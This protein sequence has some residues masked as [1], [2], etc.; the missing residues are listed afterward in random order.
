[1]TKNINFHELAALSATE[2]GRLLMRT[3][4]DLSH[5][6]PRVQTIMDE[7]KTGG[8]NALRRL[9]LEL[10]KADIS[11]NGL[12]ATEAEFDAAEKT[13]APELREAMQFAAGSI[14]R[15]HQDQMPEEMWL[16]EIRPGAFC[17]DR[18][19]PIPSVACYVPRGKGAFPSVAMMTTLP[20]K[21]AGVRK[22]AIFTPP[23]EEGKVDAATLFAAR[24][25]GVTEVYKAG[26]AQAVAAA[27]FGTETIPKFAKIIGPGSP[28]VAAAKRLVTHLI[29]TG[30]PAGPSELIVLADE[31]ADGRLAGLDLLIEAEHGPDSSAYLVTWSRSVAEAA[32][33]AIPEYWRSMG[34]QRVA[35]SSAVLSGPIGGIVL[36]RDRREAIA[37]INDYAPEHL[38]ILSK[39]P[40]QYL[41]EIEHAGE[42]LLGE[43]TPVTLGNFVLGPNHVLPTNGWA[44]TASPV[45]VYDFLKRTSIAYVTSSGYPEVARHARTLARYEGF[46]AHANAVSPIRKR[47]LG[48]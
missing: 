2:R 14:T 6:L 46:D 44:R 8:D 25:A 37:F 48:G 18:T 19:R 38:E 28:W 30:S 29:D 5:I 15:F 16:H 7:V 45:S 39:E 31:T 40:F 21:V 23:D 43:H 41:G 35:F 22:V 13:I 24:L 47:L 10:D 9:A 36:G 3:E 4:A 33:N 20:A 1:M 42:I 34:E 26:G 12:A 17:G 11:D 27:A 32:L